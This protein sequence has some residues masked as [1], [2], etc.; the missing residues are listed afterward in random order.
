MVDSTKCLPACGYLC[1]GR[2]LNKAEKRFH[3]GFCLKV[4]FAEGKF[5]LNAAR[6]NMK[7]TK[8]RKAPWLK[9]ACD[10]ATSPPPD[11]YLQDGFIRWVT[12][13]LGYDLLTFRA[14][15]SM[16]LV[17]DN[18]IQLWTEQWISREVSFCFVKMNGWKKKAPNTILGM[19]WNK[20][21]MTKQS[22]QSNSSNEWP[23][24]VPGLLCQMK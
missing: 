21:K 23:V 20:I 17:E 3:W 6:L 11:G 2:T 19:W 24:Q 15:Y 18:L 1:W 22:I 13:T 5:P 10:D 4:A 9:S 16:T 14:V 12:F 8:Y 7:G